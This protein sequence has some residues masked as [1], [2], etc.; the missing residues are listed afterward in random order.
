METKSL[1]TFGQW[2]VYADYIACAATGYE[3]PITLLRTP[4]VDWDRHMSEKRWCVMADF[5]AA[6]ALL[7]RI[8]VGDEVSHAVL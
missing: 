7:E 8:A 5:R 4:V 6:R 3:L 2:D 1:A